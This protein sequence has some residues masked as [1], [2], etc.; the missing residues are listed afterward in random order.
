MN[1]MF[2]ELARKAIEYA[3][4]KK[5]D[6]ISSKDLQVTQLQNVTTKKYHFFKIMPSK[7]KSRK[8]PKKSAISRPC[9]SLF[10]RM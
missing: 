5:I 1:E 7:Y 8:I 10:C 9:Y 6:I 4:D 3:I 2:T